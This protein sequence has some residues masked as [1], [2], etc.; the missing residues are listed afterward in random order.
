MAEWVMAS[1]IGVTMLLLQFHVKQAL[2]WGADGHLVT[3]LIAEV[4]P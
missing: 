1:A 3:C 2:A 4:N